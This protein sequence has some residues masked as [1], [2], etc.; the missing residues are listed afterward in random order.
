MSSERNSY[1]NIFIALGLFG[2]TQIFQIIIA[3]IRNKFVAILLGPVGMGI[4]GLLTSTTNLVNSITSMG[5]RTSA[6]RDI[7][8]A[9]E[10]GDKTR[11]SIVSAVMKKLVWGTGILGMLIVFFLADTLSEWTFQSEDNSWMFRLLSATLLF[12]QLRVGQN[13][14]MQGTFNY[15]YMAKSSILGSIVGLFASIPLYYIWRTNAIAPVL[16]IV[17][18]AALLLSS[19]YSHKIKIPS[20]QVSMKDVFAEGKVMIALGIAVALSGILREGKTYFT[21]I[22]IANNGLIYEVG[23]YTAAISIATQ[24]INIILNA[25]SSDYSPR[26]AA[27]SNN[28]SEFVEV[29]NRQNKLMLTIITPFVL[30]LIIFIHPFVRILYSSEFLE[31]SGMIEWMMLGMFF[32]TTSWCLSYTL[33]AKGQ[34][35]SFLINETISTLYSFALFVVG[36]KLLH[37]TGIGIGYCLSYLLYTIQFYLICKRNFNFK[38]TPDNIKLLLTQCSFV[39]VIFGVLKC[40]G[41]SHWRYV[42]GILALLILG[43]Y[44]Y[45]GLNEM[46][47]IK[48]LINSIR[49]KFLKK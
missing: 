23:M 25:M 2:G 45:S 7:S 49:D 34:A 16:F 26:L 41:Y 39:F 40:L 21:R 47:N 10:S 6:V 48:E 19:Y 27:V 33:V 20:I 15:K 22:F 44:T 46:I 30:A 12:D 24:Y 11:I 17:S 9:Y 35:K 29:I 14:L 4:S 42:F 1:K 36:Y 28:E 32:R 8:R 31:I 43:I 18:F 37:F 5:L 13:V 38:Y 3:I